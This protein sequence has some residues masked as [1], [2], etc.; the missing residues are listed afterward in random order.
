MQFFSTLHRD[1]ARRIAGHFGMTD[2]EPIYSP[3]AAT[4]HT[5]RYFHGR[6]SIHVRGDACNPVTQELAHI[7]FDQLESL[8]NDLRRK[9]LSCGHVY[10]ETDHER[11]PASADATTPRDSAVFGQAAG[12]GRYTRPDLD[13]EAMGHSDM[14]SRMS[15]YRVTPQAYADE[16][17][18]LEMQRADSDL[19]LF[20]D[21]GAVE[22]IALA[23]QPPISARR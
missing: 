10:V 6:S 9:L 23:E 12:Y 5:R 16:M 8:P 2:F 19:R 13:L 7:G 17:A 20:L 14:N 22:A 11:M 3:V 1:D 15:F 4:D 21:L 18:R